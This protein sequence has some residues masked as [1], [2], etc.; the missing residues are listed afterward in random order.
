MAQVFL[1][2]L[3]AFATLPYTQGLLATLHDGALPGAR[4]V[5][6]FGLGL[7]AGQIVSVF[8]FDRMRGPQWWQ[9]PFFGIFF[10]GVA[11]ALIAYPA[12]YWVGRLQSRWKSLVIIATLF[13]LL[14]GNVVR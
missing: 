2:W 4:P 10:G 12:A 14:V 1:A 8:V 5:A 11:L 3:I 6:T 9:A 7:L 13:P